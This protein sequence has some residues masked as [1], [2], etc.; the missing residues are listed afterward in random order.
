MHDVRCLVLAIISPGDGRHDFGVIPHDD[1]LAA[2]WVDGRIFNAA[3]LPRGEP[4]AVYDDIRALARVVELRGFS[5][6]AHSPALDDDA[7]FQAL[8]DEP[9]EVDGGINADGGEGDCGVDAWPQLGLREDSE[10]D[11]SKQVRQMCVVDG[12]AHV[13]HHVFVPRVCLQQLG[14]PGARC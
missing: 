14:H 11:P 4:S 1:Y 5:H 13:R 10:L 12:G 3:E 7:V 8:P 6:M 2:S 9:W